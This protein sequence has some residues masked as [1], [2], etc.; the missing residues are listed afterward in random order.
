MIDIAITK[1]LGDFR[2]QAQVQA[3]R[4]VTA[5]FGPSG[6]GKSSLINAIAGIL[7]PDDGHIAVSDRILYDRAAE[8]NVPI[9]LRRVGYVFQNAR[10]FPH[11]T[12]DKNLRYGGHHDASRIIEMLG[13]ARL[14]KRYPRHLSGGEQQRVAL[15]RALMSDPA[16]LL[17]DEPL[18]ALD[19][20]RKAEIMP[21]L[22]RLRD[23][24]QI[25]ILYVSHDISEV[26]RLATTIVM[27]RDGGVICSGS[28]QD[29]LS[30]PELV[31]IIGARDAGAVIKAKILRID[32][33][34]DLTTVQFSGGE[35]VLPGA[36]GLVGQGVRLRIPAQD[37]ILSR[38]KPEAM[39]A[40]NILPVTITKLTFGK[41]SGVAVGL[42]AGKDRILARITGHSVKRLDL[43]Q[44]DEI[45]AILKATAVA[46]SDTDI[47]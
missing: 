40:I 7:E 1:R 17:M 28:T 24:T 42:M 30:D 33:V 16:I 6:S 15:G 22:I 39:S 4:G 23:T 43:K 46:S 41:A 20:P 19:A 31:P 8:I 5:L 14:L 45:Y 3:P 25:P 9:H 27:M 13:L 18:A 32:P 38:H 2:L 47:A 12:V 29:I 36:L 37:V 26:A 21:Y 10:L 11:Y 44:G 34:E 35:I